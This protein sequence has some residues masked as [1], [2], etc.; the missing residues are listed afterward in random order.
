ME[1]NTKADESA[2]TFRWLRRGKQYRIIGEIYA[3]TESISG[4]NKRGGNI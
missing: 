3:L 1:E 2:C 4:L